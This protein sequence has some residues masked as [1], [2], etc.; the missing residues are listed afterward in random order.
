MVIL[1]IIFDIS[2]ILDEI[3]CVDAKECNR[4]CENPVGCSN[5]AYPK[6]VLE[7]MPYGKSISMNNKI[8]E[9]MCKVQTVKRSNWQSMI[10]F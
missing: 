7:L 4:I 10:R 2:F 1:S 8:N 9:I 5:I 6:L 3:A